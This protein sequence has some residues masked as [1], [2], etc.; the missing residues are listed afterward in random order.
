MRCLLNTK[1]KTQSWKND[2]RKR[3]NE[4]KIGNKYP[5]MALTEFNQMNEELKIV[6]TTSHSLKSLLMAFALLLPADTEFSLTK[7]VWRKEEK[8]VEIC[9]KQSNS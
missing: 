9:W 8:P 3:M 5:S 6:S 2:V 7:A 1:T 4:F